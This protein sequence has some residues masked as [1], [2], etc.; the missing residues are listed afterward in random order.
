MSMRKKRSSGRKSKLKI[1]GATLIALGFFIFPIPLEGGE[2]LLI[3]GLTPFFS[4]LN[5][6]AVVTLLGGIL[7]LLGA[8][9]LGNGR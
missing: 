4:F 8:L 6:L 7:I 5:A 2:T 1:I 9:L 3:L